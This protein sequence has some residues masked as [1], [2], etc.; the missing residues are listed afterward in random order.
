VPVNVIERATLSLDPGPD[1]ASS[2]RRQ[3]RAL[4]DGWGC[5]GALV[6]DTILVVSELV[7]NAVLHAGNAVS[8]AL[9]LCKDRVRVEVADR[10]AVMPA[11]SSYDL[12]AHTGRGLTLVGALA[13]RWGA[14]SQD[15]GKLVWAEVPR[16]GRDLDQQADTV[17]ETPSR[18]RT[19][20]LE[21]I[22]FL[23][24]SVP[25]YLA[26]QQQNDAISRDVDLLLIGQSE[27]LNLP[28][29]DGL[30]AAAHRLRDRFEVPAGSFRLVVVA[31]EAAGE[32][33]VDLEAY[34]PPGVGQMAGAYVELLEEVED[35]ARQGYLFIDPPTPETVRL[36]RWFTEEL[37]RQKEGI[38]PAPMP[39]P[40]PD[41]R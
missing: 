34:M 5:D 35:Y 24:V 25:A 37:I 32:T 20:G 22:L 40:P 19:E 41:A 21:R 28:V 29:P 8:V 23:D 36:R 4:L 17:T 12:D 10:S 3:T 38:A 14:E 31:A 2:A 9:V 30:L 11:P 18:G 39:P 6:D 33:T 16:V 15:G 1:G 26:L 13:E 7:A 27:G